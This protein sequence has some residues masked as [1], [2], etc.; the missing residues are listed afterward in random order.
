MSWKRLNEHPHALA[1]SSTLALTSVP[2][3]T[4]LPAENKAPS[5]SVLLLGI[6][7]T[8]RSGKLAAPRSPPFNRSVAVA[9]VQAKDQTCSA[10]RC[11]P[12]AARSPSLDPSPSY[13][14]GVWHNQPRLGI[15]HGAA[16]TNTVGTAITVWRRLRLR[17]TRKCGRDFLG[18]RDLS[19]LKVALLR[20]RKCRFFESKE[21]L[22]RA[23]HTLLPCAVTLPSARPCRRNSGTG[24]STPICRHYRAAS[25]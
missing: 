8:G 22:A 24:I 23:A 6:G 18:W 4:G 21:M 15:A 12:G 20:N 13:G 1:R 17:R 11:W 25:W 2:T 3:P 19:N 10:G 7:N 5:W 14:G 16:Q 9:S